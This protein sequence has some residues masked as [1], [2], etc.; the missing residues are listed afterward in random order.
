MVF[1]AIASANRD[2][3]QFANP[4]TLDITREPNRHLAFGLGT[5]FLPRRF[6]GPSGGSNRHR[7]AAAASAEA[8]AGKAVRIATLARRHGAARPGIAAGGIVNRSVRVTPSGPRH[9]SV[10]QGTGLFKG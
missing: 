2:E 4:D 7:D 10:D 5:H 9:W 8:A 3:R 6:A 1:A